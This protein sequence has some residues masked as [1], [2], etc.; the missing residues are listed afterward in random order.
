[1]Y[2]YGDLTWIGDEL[3]LGRRIVAAIEPDREWPGLWRARVGQH[4]SDTTNRSRA[5]DAA[6][7]LALDDLKGR[8]GPIR[9]P[10]ISFPEQPVS[11]GLST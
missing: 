3:R 7:C 8:S 10:W 4:L 6:V 5:K 11:V 2:A 9:S 1:M